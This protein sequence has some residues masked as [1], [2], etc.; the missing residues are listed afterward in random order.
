MCLVQDPSLHSRLNQHAILHDVV[1]LS[2]GHGNCPAPR[3]CLTYVIVSRDALMRGKLK[4]KQIP[5]PDVPNPSKPGLI[6]ALDD[7]F[8]PCKCGNGLP[9]GRHRVPVRGGGLPND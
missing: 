2:F 6:L 4:G 1:F 5:R 7:L 3:D 9:F 8:I